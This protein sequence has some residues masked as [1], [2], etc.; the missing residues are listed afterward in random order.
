MDG[1]GFQALAVGDLNGDGIADV[2]IAWDDGN[3]T[4]VSTYTNQGT[5]LVFTAAGFVCLSD[6]F[7]IV[8]GDFD[9]DGIIGGL[10]L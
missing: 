10:Y 9:K 7:G 3:A 6:P 8:I 4:K 2:A 5:G 1:A